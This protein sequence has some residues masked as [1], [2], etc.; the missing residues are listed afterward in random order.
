LAVST[1]VF[2]SGAYAA[3]AE[4]FGEIPKARQQLPSHPSAQLEK[5]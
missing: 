3:F 5:A 4:A 2:V 1:F